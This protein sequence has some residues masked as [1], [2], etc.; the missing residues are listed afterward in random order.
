MALKTRRTIL[1]QDGERKVEIF[2]RQDGT[3]GF[4]EYFY[5]TEEK[6]WCPSRLLKNSGSCHP[7]EPK[8]TKDLC[9]CLISQMPGFFASL[10]MTCAMVFQQPARSPGGQISIMDTLD[11]AVFEALGRISWLKAES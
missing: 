11:R 5:D 9:I 1:S 8:A 2:Q 10:R 4:E 3:F 7:E 6:A